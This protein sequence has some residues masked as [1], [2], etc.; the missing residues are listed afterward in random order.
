[1]SND[2]LVRRLVREGGELWELESA[3]ED[4]RAERDEW[5]AICTE[6]EDLI[7]ERREREGGDE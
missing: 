7:G 4:A 3:L 2:T 1:M 5:D 6:L